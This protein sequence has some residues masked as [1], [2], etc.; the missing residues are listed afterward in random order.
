M[1]DKPFA[2]IGVNVGNYDPAK[3]K[4]IMDKEKL[5]WRSLADRGEIA[6]K[7]NQPGTPLYYVIDPAGII[8]YK[9]YGYPGE[10]ALD[11]AVEKQIDEVDR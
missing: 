3:L 7:W 8:R 4:E 5:N 6:P 1:K 10:K 9:W 2:L 11:A